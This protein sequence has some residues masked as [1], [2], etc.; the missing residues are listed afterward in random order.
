MFIPWD[1]KARI[2]CSSPREAAWQSAE[3]RGSGLERRLEVR[4]LKKEDLGRVGLGDV[5]GGGTSLAVAVLTSCMTPMISLV[6]SYLSSYRN[7]QERANS[8][9][10]LLIVS[11]RDR[12]GA[13]SIL[14]AQE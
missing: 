4:A 7:S 13:E 6:G 12:E 5:Y 2:C 1:I 3:T 8:K 14:A 10:I 11:R 9:D